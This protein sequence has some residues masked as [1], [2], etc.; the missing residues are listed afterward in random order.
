M[1]TDHVNCTSQLFIQRTR[2]STNLPLLSKNINKLLKALDD[3]ELN[4]QKLAE[5]IMKFPE[6]S[7][8]LVYLANS[9]WISS[10]KP[11]TSVDRAC[12][13][14]GHSIVKSVS[15]GMSISS[16]F[17][18][19]KCPGFKVDRFWTTS[20][21]VSKGAGLL[22][23]RI[24]HK[25]ECNDF[26]QTSQSAGLLHNIGL[27]W[28]ADQL[29][30]ETNKALRES[31]TD[32]GLTVNKALIKHTGTDYC[33]VGSL[34]CC[35]MKFP[36]VLNTAIRFQRD[37]HYRQSFWEVAVLVGTA[38]NMVTALHNKCEDVS[39]NTRLNQLGIDC[40]EQNAVYRQLVDSFEKTQELVKIM[41]GSR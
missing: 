31:Q 18:T 8:R 7:A 27:L 9:A 22:A 11:V 38:A 35:Q 40:C 21:L 23:S 3:T 32:S 5:I 29:P 39:E 30:K 41:S 37:N 34:L 33:E 14:L 19:R 28:L 20:L 36:D 2:R 24:S 17:D 4:H 10:A 1:I 25:V 12:F 6:I 26:E 16:C 15:L 13:I